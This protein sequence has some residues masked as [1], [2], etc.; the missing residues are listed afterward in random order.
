[1][2]KALRAFITLLLCAVLTIG[3]VSAA[4]APVSPP[5]NAVSP[6]PAGLREEVVY[7]N[8]SGSG[9]IDEIYAVSLLTLPDAA[10]YT[11][12][13]DYASVTNLTDTA[14]LTLSGNQVAFSAEAGSFYYQGTMRTKEL[15]W[16]ISITYLLDGAEISPAA[17]AGQTG[18]VAIRIAT[19]M[20]PAVDAAYFENYMLTISATLD[21]SLCRNIT[22]SGGMT[23]IAGSDKRITFMAMPGDAADFSLETDAVGFTMPGIEISALPL[24][25]SISAP[26]TAG[27]KADLNEL[28]DAIAQLSDGTAQLKNGALELKNGSAELRGG[29]ALFAGGIGELSGNAASL[30]GGSA[31]I[32]DALTALSGALNG[33]PAVDGTQSGFS[34]TGLQQL[35]GALDQTAAGLQEMSAGLGALKDSFSKAYEALKAAVGQI[36]VDTPAEAALGKLYADNPEKKELLDLLA[37]YVKGGA[38]TK[39]TFENVKPAFDAVETSLSETIAGAGQMTQGLSGMS[40][41]IKTGLAG[42]GTA[43]QL[44]QLGEGLKQLS[45]QY[46]EFHSGLTEFTAGA[47]QLGSQYGEL[48]AGISGLADGTSEL[49]GGIAETSDGTAELNDGVR[50]LPARIDEEIEKLMDT[51][52]KSDY[53]P[54][55]FVSGKNVNTASV[56]FVMKTAPIE[57]PEAPAAAAPEAVQESFWTRLMALFK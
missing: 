25:I 8:L 14:P 1:M 5:E 20:N 26:D 28:T 43:A 48:H 9:M 46:G 3:T 36:P 44:G 22:V 21:A 50:D 51:Y 54:V 23:A 56:Q 31:Q 2:K 17:L 57:L 34:L 29:S 6:N 27:M 4:S 55:S 7:A 18:H 47:S 41:Q 52:D 10:T 13:G 12:Y 19:S 49:Y 15:P 40:A 11:D 39:A 16:I 45:A 24:S 53:Q 37:G 42:D 32:K 35:P 30:L 33:A 38:G